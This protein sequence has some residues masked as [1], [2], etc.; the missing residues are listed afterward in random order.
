MSGV[1]LLQHILS[2]QIFKVSVK[3]Q[4]AQW[5]SQVDKVIRNEPTHQSLS[6]GHQF[7]LKTETSRKLFVMIS[8]WPYTYKTGMSGYH[9]CDGMKL[10]NNETV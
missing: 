2:V 1:F 5:Q 6:S 8:T 4:H 7:D 9:H 10:L 3:S